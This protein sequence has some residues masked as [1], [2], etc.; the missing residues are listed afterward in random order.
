MY[1]WLNHAQKDLDRYKGVK[2]LSLLVV[3]KRGVGISDLITEWVKSI[4]CPDKCNHCHHCQQLVAGTHSDVLKV[5]SSSCSVDDVREVIQ[6]VATKPRSSDTKIVFIDNA[7]SMTIQASNAILKV[8]EEPPS[9]VLFILRVTSLNE[10]LPTL[11]SRCMV[12]NIATP[13]PQDIEKWLVAEFN[14]SPVIARAKSILSA[15]CPMLAKDMDVQE[16]FNYLSKALNPSLNL[17]EIE[18]SPED[19][20]EKIQS[21]QAWIHY[22]LKQPNELSVKSKIMLIE[23]YQELIVFTKKLRQ[24]VVW[25]KDILWETLHIQL[26]MHYLKF[27]RNR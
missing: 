22:S 16:S 5:D 9:N 23:W 25:N 19:L 1:P 13:S 18:P 21:L 24:K 7:S 8:L 20:F 17:V 27:S 3:S 26:K 6:F 12:I 4:Y 14:Y 15:G 11:V 2:P 10:T